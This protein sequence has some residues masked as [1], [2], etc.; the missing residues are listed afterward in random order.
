MLFIYLFIFV[1]PIGCSLFDFFYRF[2]HG[3][4]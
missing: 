4:L 3:K 1:F 2:Y